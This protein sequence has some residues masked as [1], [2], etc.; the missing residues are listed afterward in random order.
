MPLTAVGLFREA[1]VGEDQE[2]IQKLAARSRERGAGSL[3]AEVR[4]GFC[5]LPV[6]GF[7]RLES[8]FLLQLVRELQL[9][10][11]QFL[12]PRGPWGWAAEA[13]AAGLLRGH[14]SG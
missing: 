3:H 4:V 10:M 5:W 14:T 2:T 12:H 9:L 8:P 6:C 11:V 1:G 13:A 7:R